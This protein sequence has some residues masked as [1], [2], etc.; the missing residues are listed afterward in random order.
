MITYNNFMPFQTSHLKKFPI[1]YF[2]F[3]VAITIQF[4][5]IEYR[6]FE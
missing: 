4:L 6:E 1:A 5:F 3:Y 2:V